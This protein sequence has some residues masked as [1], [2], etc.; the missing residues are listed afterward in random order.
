MNYHYKEFFW[1]VD[2]R[3]MGLKK[4]PDVLPEVVDLDPIPG[5]SSPNSSSL[6]TKLDENMD[7]SKKKKFTFNKNDKSEPPKEDNKS[8]KFKFSEDS[9]VDSSPIPSS[10]SGYC[11]ILIGLVEWILY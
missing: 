3:I 10:S 4:S 6:K 9:K 1:V 11:S 5:T 2:E 8:K 7:S